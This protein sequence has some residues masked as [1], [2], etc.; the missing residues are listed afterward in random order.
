MAWRSA[1]DGMY[2][3]P[4]IQTQPG[5]TSKYSPAPSSARELPR[6]KARADGRLERRLVAAEPCV[7]VDAKERDLRIGDELRRERSQI[8]RQ[9]REDLDHRPRTCCS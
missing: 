3:P 5:A 7:A 6:R 8:N 1:V 4:P 2:M 9:S